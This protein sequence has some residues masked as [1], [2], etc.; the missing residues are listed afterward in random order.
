MF[1]NHGLCNPS[2]DHDVFLEG[3]RMRHIAANMCSLQA[4]FGP[5]YWAIS[6]TLQ[7]ILEDL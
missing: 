1:R 5:E 2:L 4:P 6:E 7:F 3:F